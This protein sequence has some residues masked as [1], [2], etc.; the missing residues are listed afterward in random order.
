MGGGVATPAQTSLFYIFNC[1]IDAGTVPIC[2]IWL[3]RNKVGKERCL[4]TQHN[5]LDVG[6]EPT[7]TARYSEGS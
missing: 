2:F 4:R 3:G 1:F 7:G 6:I 5:E